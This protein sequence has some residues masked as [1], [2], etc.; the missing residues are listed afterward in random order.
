MKNTIFKRL[1]FSIVIL[2]NVCTVAAQYLEFDYG[3]AYAYQYTVH[4]PKGT[5][6]Q[7]FAV[8]DPLPS[9]IVTDA[10]AY[11]HSTY[12]NA[13]VISPPTNSYN[14]HGYSFLVSNGDDPFWVNDPSPNWSDGSYMEVSS[15][16][17]GDV[18]IYGSNS[19]SAVKSSSYP[20]KY[21]SKW[22]YGCLVVHAIGYMPSAYSP[23]IRK[24][25]R[26][27]PNE[28][29]GPS[30]IGGSETGSYSLSYLP[31]HRT[32]VW[33]YDT[34]LLT[35]VSSSGR[36]I[37]LR[38]K[39]S[40]TSGD[41]TL[42]ARFYDGSGNLK[43]TKRFYIGVGGPHSQNVSVRVVRSSDGVEVYPSGNG[44]APNSYYYAYL[45]G[46]SACSNIT[47]SPDSHLQNLQ[48]SN[49]MMY[50]KTDSQGWGTLNIYGTVSR[51]GINKQIKGITLYGG[52]S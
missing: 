29:S 34:N 14:C 4:T 17:N 6:Y 38:P 21:V 33:N 49:T 3:Y 50:F 31:S 1:I 43:E 37:V 36:T 8:L 12:P 7:A 26:K 52:G 15:P 35:C 45:S 46:A 13:I 40:A 27:V 44:L 11:V 22:G 25:Y 32:L 16:A 2:L 28:L 9:D 19:H 41:A 47:W 10:T 24:Y 5:P 42:Y 23:S 48:S 30:I 39:T 18:V 51:Y 20:G